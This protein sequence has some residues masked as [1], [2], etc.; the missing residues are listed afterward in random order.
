MAEVKI[1]SGLHRMTKNFQ[2]NWYKTRGIPLPS[3]LSD[4]PDVGKS[5]AAAKRVSVAPRQTVAAKPGSV[6]AINAARQAKYMEKGGRQPIG[7]GGSGGSSVKAGSDMS[8]ARGIA[9]SIKAGVNPK[10]SLNRYTG[11]EKDSESKKVQESAERPTRPRSEYSDSR[12]EMSS[13]IAAAV[14]RAKARRAKEQEKRGM[15]KESKMVPI[16][17]AMDNIRQNKIYRMQELL[18]N[19]NPVQIK[20]K[21]GKSGQVYMVQGQDVYFLHADTNK[22]FKTH[23]DNVDVIGHQISGEK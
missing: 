12:K 21:G 3:H 11:P 13:K 17:Q 19:R 22:K 9:Q 4:S 20:T 5:A 14:A 10:V 15:V 18:T 23:V 2:K 6:R 1:P 16:L 7:A 8:T